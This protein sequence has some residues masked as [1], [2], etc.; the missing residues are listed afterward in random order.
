MT[1]CERLEVEL[2]KGRIMTPMEIINELKIP[3]YTS[4]ISD[5]R[6]KGL[7]IE[8]DESK[9][10]GRYYLAD[11]RPENVPGKGD[12]FEYETS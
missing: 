6:E 7:A 5:L 8:C 4:R 11:N 9:G 2:R 1:Q 12:A 3:K 10:Y